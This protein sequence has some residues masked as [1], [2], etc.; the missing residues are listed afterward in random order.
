M[1]ARAADNTRFKLIATLVKTLSISST[2]ADTLLKR[3]L[4]DTAIKTG[5]PNLM[6]NVSELGSLVRQLG[7]FF[8]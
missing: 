5:L 3:L 4:R 1:N 2:E 6:D 8:G 7:D